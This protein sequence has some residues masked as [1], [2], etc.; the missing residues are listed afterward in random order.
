MVRE[1]LIINGVD[2][3]LE[4]SLNPALTYSIQDIKQLDKRKSTY[5]KTVTLPGS[6]VLNDLFNFIFEIN[7]DGTFNANLKADAVYLVDSQTIL[8]GFIRLNSVTFLDNSSVIYKCTLL[9]STA[10]FFTDLGEQ[11]LTDIQDLNDFEH[12]WNELEQIASWDTQIQ[13]QGNPIPFQYGRGYVYP[14]LDYGQNTALESFAATE[15]Y[16]AFYVKE[17]WDRIFAD[18]GYTYTSNFLNN[19]GDKR[20]VRAIVPF[21]GDKF[22]L[23]SA[24]IN[25]RKFV[26]DTPTFISPMVNLESKEYPYLNPDPSSFVSFTDVTDAG[27]I[28]NA[29]V[30]TVPGTGSYSISTSIEVTALFKPDATEEVNSKSYTRLRLYVLRDDGSG[31]GLQEIGSN[32]TRFGPDYNYDFP[33][34]GT[35]ETTLNPTPPDDNYCTSI[36]YQNNTD[37][38]NPI[39]RTSPNP[40]NK[41]VVN[42]TDIPLFSGDLIKVKLVA[43]TFIYNKTGTQGVP[44]PHK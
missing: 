25:N 13:F 8:N 32:T 41:M 38:M 3:P 30:F 22:G 40:P 5:S 26:A 17:L 9:G 34:G 10:N 4:G 44:E 14:L 11:E 37:T 2:V 15:L 6:K 42:L 20:F 31:G 39:P 16:P 43:R 27:N 1:Q 35:Y 28:H 24:Q 7:I 21:N 36:L 12:S 19:T 23:S 29:G 33:I 18:A